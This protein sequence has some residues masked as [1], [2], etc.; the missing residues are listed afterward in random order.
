MQRPDFVDPRVAS[1]HW[2]AFFDD[3]YPRLGEPLNVVVSANS[4]NRILRSAEGL[5]DWLSSIQYGYQC[6]GLHRGK[7][8]QAHL[9]DGAGFVDQDG[10][11]SVSGEVELWS[12]VAWWH[13]LRIACR[14]QSYPVGNF[15]GDAT[16]F[17]LGQANLWA[18]SYWFQDYP[19]ACEGAVF[20]AASDEDDLLGAHKII[21]N[22]YDQARDTIV[23][24]ATRVGGTISPLSGV[25][26]TATAVYLEG[27]MPSGPGGINHN[28]PIDG[29]I[30]LLRVNVLR[31]AVEVT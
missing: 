15:A 10:P 14:R 22:G 11:A 25:T 4:D 26:Y 7:K 20:F 23:R 2:R 28:V 9:G 19:R 6:L 29:R 5:Q 31:E 30:A 12:A 8:Q 13:L 1:G 21:E 24:Q 3:L 16:L 27:Y 17:E 18:C